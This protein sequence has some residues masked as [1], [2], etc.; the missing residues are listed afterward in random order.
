MDGAG[1]RRGWPYGWSKLCRGTQQPA[2]GS[3]LGTVVRP[4]P[5]WQRVRP[6]P[7]PIAS[8]S[9]TGRQPTCPAPYLS[10]RRQWR[11][12]AWPESNS[13]LS[14]HSGTPTTK[15]EDML[16]D[17]R[18]GFICDGKLP[19]LPCWSMHYCNKAEEGS[20]SPS[21]HQQMEYWT[22]NCSSR[23]AKLC[24]RRHGLAG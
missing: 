18:F 12:K 17:R 13:P 3:A 14:A 20:C 6:H 2:R 21:V 4:E 22:T 11:Q 9:A 19:G 8:P 7:L 15:A 10:L 1:R 5:P 24:N 16:A 23:A